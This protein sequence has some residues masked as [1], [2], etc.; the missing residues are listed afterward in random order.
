MGELVE[1]PPRYL[2]HAVVHGRLKSGGG[3]FRDC[4]LDLVQ[5]LSHRYL[6]GDPGYGVAGGL[7]GQGRTAADPGVDFDHEIRRLGLPFLAQG[8]GDDGMGLQSELDVAPTLDSQPSDD[9]EAGRAQHLAFLVAQG[10][11]GGHHDAVAG[12]DAHGVHVLHVADGDAIVGAVPHHL[13]LD[14]FPADQRAFQQDLG[15][16]AGRQSRADEALELFF[17]VGDAAAAAAQGVCGPDHQRQAHA[18]G[19]GPGLFHGVDAF[20]LGLGLVYLVEKGA[21]EITVFGAPDGL[22]RGAQQSDVVL[23][24]DAGI[25]Q[26]HSQ[27]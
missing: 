7:A 2:E 3:L 20:V 8:L 11:A 18:L 6:R 15:D 10:L 21:E 19:G 24:Q 25:G 4:V 22:Q 9:L 16:G 17:G 1:G 5:L 23:L 12:M 13:V 14:L 26:G 27:V